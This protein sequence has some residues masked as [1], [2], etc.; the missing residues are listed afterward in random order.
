MGE[1]PERYYPI[2]GDVQTRV[3][4]DPKRRSVM[5]EPQSEVCGDCKQFGEAVSCQ[6]CGGTGWLCNAKTDVHVDPD[7]NACVG[8]ERKPRK[9]R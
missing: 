3:G 6:R 1:F 8:F 7:T 9:D 5:D 2:P 4:E